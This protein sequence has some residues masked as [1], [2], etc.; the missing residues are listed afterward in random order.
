MKGPIL[1]VDTGTGNLFSLARSFER[2]GRPPR[3]SRDPEAIAGAGILVLPG[4]ASFPAI[5][6]GVEPLRAELVRR[7]RAGTPLLG[8]CAGLQVLAGASE[9]GPGQGLGLL[10][11]EVVRLPGPL[12]PHMGW[13]PLRRTPDPMLLGLGG[14]MVDPEMYYAHSYA[15]PAGTAG[16][17]ATSFHGI[18]F[19]AVVRAGSVVGVQFHPER[20]GRAGAAFLAAFLGWA[21]G[22]AG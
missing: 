1:I 9:E 14:P 6:R 2:L 18:E 20:S 22:V 5:A 11:G 7:V 16:T 19:A 10:R 4:V 15:L 17:V 12:L 13:S 3:I 8:I 21:E